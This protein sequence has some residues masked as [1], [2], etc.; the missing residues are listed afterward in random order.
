MAQ[1]SSALCANTSLTSL[2]LSN[3]G[4]L[5]MAGIRALGEALRRDG[6]RLRSLDLSF[7]QLAPNRGHSRTAGAQQDGGQPGGQRGGSAAEEEAGALWSVFAQALAGNTSLQ[8]LN[9][10]HCGLTDSGAAILA[11]ALQ[12][13]VTLASLEVAGFSEA[14]ARRAFAALLQREG[15]ALTSIRATGEN[16]APINIVGGPSTSVARRRTA[17]L[18]VETSVSGAGKGAAGKAE[19]EGVDEEKALIRALPLATQL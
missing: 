18:L 14:A 13:N 11:A 6:G 5:C 4:G 19:G 9:L 16:F 17:A 2:S 15:A 8:Q 10:S 1:L 3:A 7:C 12:Q